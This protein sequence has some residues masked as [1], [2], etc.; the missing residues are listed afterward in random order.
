ME[1][2]GAVT[3]SERT[4]YRTAVTQDRHRRRADT[5][6]HEMAHMWFGDL[7]TMRWWNGLWLNESFATLLA[8]TAV[9]KATDFGGSWQAFFSDM[10]KWAYWEDQLV[11]THPIE[12]PVPDTD[13]AEA[14]FD[15][16]TYGK[17]ASTLKQLRFYLGEDDFREGLQRYFQKYAY[18][19]TTISDF[20]KMLEEASSEDLNQWQKTWLQTAGVNTLRA[21]WKCET[22][23]ESGKSTLSQFNLIQLP[24]NASNEIRPHRTQIALY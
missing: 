14:N 8:A 24:A 11:T 2:V 7:V 4:V 12:L 9:D 5:I 19:N 15:G 23:P 6:L 10:K 13:S 16:I 22:H 17:G 21:E 3:F 1:N 18:R 20:M